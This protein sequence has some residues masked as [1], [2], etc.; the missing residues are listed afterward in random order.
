MTL[1]RREKLVVAVGA[2][3][4]VLLL[5]YRVG[6][7]PA[8]GRLRTL[9][10][11]VAQKEREVQEM[12]ALR[13]TYLTQKRLLEDLN[14]SLTQ[15]GQEFAIFSVLEDLAKKSGVKNNIM[16]MKP[17]LSSAGELYRE[18]SVEMRLEGIDLQQ[19]IRYLYDVERAPQILRVRS[20]HIKPRPSDQN[21]LDVTFQVSTFYL[22]EKT[23]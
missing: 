17:A 5:L 16:Y 9:D 4:V 6:L 12:K 20:M 3:V 23:G 22:Q 18:S 11:L 21:V 1:G 8:L 10:R 7:S 2:V 13:T 14:H 19:L 15:R